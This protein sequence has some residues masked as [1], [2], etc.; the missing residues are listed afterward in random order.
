MVACVF[1]EQ[2]TMNVHNM[3]ILKTKL[4]TVLEKYS[5][6]EY[7]DNNRR[8]HNLIANVLAFEFKKSYE[9]NKIPLYTGY[10]DSNYLY[11]STKEKKELESPQEEAN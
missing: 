1:S 5:H 10:F 11:T 9:D 4:V 3:D 6:N 8:F 2:Y 7:L